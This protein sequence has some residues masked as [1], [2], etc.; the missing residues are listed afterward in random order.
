[1]SAALADNQL[2]TSG[3]A[4]KGET[5]GGVGG[6]LGALDYRANCANHLAE[7]VYR[8]LGAESVAPAYE[9]E[10]PRGAE[11]M[12][13][14]YCI[15]HELGLCPKQHPAQAPREPLWLENNGTRLKLAFDCKNC[16]MVVIL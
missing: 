15:K 7:Q 11:V 2:T 10:A 9:L 16:E 8:E 13:T 1:M 6:P 5:R 3:I 12:R 14:R 4:A